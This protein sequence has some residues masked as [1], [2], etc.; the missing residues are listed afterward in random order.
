MIAEHL[1]LA[2]MMQDLSFAVIFVCKWP[3]VAG[4]RHIGKHRCEGLIPLTAMTVIMGLTGRT[5]C[6]S[7]WKTETQSRPSV[8]CLRLQPE[9]SSTSSLELHLLLWL[10]LLG[11]SSLRKEKS[12]PQTEGVREVLSGL[13][14]GQ[15]ML[16]SSWHG[17]L[18][19]PGDPEWEGSGGGFGGGSQGAVVEEDEGKEPGFRKHFPWGLGTVTDMFKITARISHEVHVRDVSMEAQRG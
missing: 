7:S 14:L 1:N 3:R 6:V 18:P 19:A 16:L 17:Q 13:H 4:G 9:S 5:C 11:P 8:L 10:T 12:S 15:E 2:S